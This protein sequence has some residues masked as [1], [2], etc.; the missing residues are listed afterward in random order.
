MVGVPD[1]NEIEK[2]NFVPIN[3]A[4]CPFWVHN[5]SQ[6]ARF[7]CMT[8]LGSHHIKALRT[9][10]GRIDQSSRLLRMTGLLFLLRFPFENVHAF[11]SQTLRF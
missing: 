5:R 10:F 8:E 2:A 1:K 9:V 4:R 3:G 11:Q 7:R 6:T